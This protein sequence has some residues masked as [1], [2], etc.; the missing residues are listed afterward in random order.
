MSLITIKWE[1]EVLKS[2]E[3]KCNNVSL[4]LPSILAHVP[5]LIIIVITI[6]FLFPFEVFST[7]LSW[8][9]LL[10]MDTT[11]NIDNY[12]RPFRLSIIRIPI[13]AATYKLSYASNLTRSHNFPLPIAPLSSTIASELLPKEFLCSP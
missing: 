3:C 6:S 9:L 12:R 1:K 4:F 13:S 10:F 8:L 11:V 7:L 5:E 2:Y